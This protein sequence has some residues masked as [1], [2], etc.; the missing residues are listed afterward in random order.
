MD[1]LWGQEGESVGGMSSS[2]WRELSL[3]PFKEG[4]ENKSS[5]LQSTGKWTTIR[6]IPW[7]S[8]AWATSELEDWAEFTPGSLLLDLTLWKFEFPGFSSL[9][10]PQVGHQ[11]LCLRYPLHFLGLCLLHYLQNLAPQDLPALL[12]WIPSTVPTNQQETE[13]EH[14]WSNAVLV[15]SGLPLWF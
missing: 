7:T 3:H 6:H 8:Q 2:W 5:L 4:E 13:D 15:Y 14:A 9:D 11:R 1:T 10:W 12:G